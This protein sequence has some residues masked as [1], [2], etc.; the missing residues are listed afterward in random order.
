MGKSKREKGH[1]D[2]KIFHSSKTLE[3]VDLVRILEGLIFDGG[4]VQC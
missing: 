2:S 4:R 3:A 1:F